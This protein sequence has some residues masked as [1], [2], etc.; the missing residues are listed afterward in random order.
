MAGLYVVG[1]LGGTNCR[2]ELLDTSIPEK[3]CQGSRPTVAK[4]KYGVHVPRFSRLRGSFLVG[5]FRSCCAPCSTNAYVGQG[6]LEAAPCRFLMDPEGA[7]GCFSGLQDGG[8]TGC[9]V[10]TPLPRGLLA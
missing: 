2:L 8:C 10:F 3:S 6:Q 9:A 1:D 7:D 4:A 5:L